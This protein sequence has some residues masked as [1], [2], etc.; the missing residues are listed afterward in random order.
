MLLSG[1][2]LETSTCALHAPPHP[3][4]GMAT[5]RGSWKLRAE[6]GSSAVC[7]GLRSQ[8]WVQLTTHL[9]LPL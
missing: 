4:A 3:E 1:L 8:R 9:G 5:T 7:L 6:D 2:A